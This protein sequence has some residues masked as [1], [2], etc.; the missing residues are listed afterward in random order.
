MSDPGYPAVP[1]DWSMAADTGCPTTLR[2]QGNISTCKLL[3]QMDTAT[4]ATDWRCYVTLVTAQVFKDASTTFV[5][6]PAER[7][8]PRQVGTQ[9]KIVLRRCR[10]MPLPKVGD[11][12]VLGMTGPCAW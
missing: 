9:Q 6:E 11:Q 10:Y 8:P 4:N 5:G 1:P 2:G 12:Y 7:P 3:A